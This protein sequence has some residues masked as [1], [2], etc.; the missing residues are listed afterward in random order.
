MSTYY[1]PTP[2]PKESELD[3][4]EFR[5]RLESWASYKMYSGVKMR[6]NGDWYAFYNDIVEGPFET[7]VAA[8]RRWDTLCYGSEKDV[9]KLNFPEKYW[10]R[11][12][13]LPNLNYY[14]P[15][16]KKNVQWV[17]PTAKKVAEYDIPVRKGKPLSLRETMKILRG[18]GALNIRVLNLHNHSTLGNW[19]LF[20]TGSSLSHEKRI[21]DTIV[22]YLRKRQLKNIPIRVTDRDESEWMVVD[23][24][25]VI[26]NIFS[27]RYRIARDLEDQWELMRPGKNRYESWTEEQLQERFGNIEEKMEALSL[28]SLIHQYQQRVEQENSPNSSF[29]VDEEEVNQLKEEIEKEE[30]EEKEKEEK[31]EEE[32]EY[33]MNDY[34]MTK[35]DFEKLRNDD[36]TITINGQR[37]QIEEVSDV[38]KE[39]IRDEQVPFIQVSESNPRRERRKK[40]RENNKRR[41][42]V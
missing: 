5:T 34:Y 42:R 18:E 11:G 39:D 29:L 41:Y 35:E 40:L 14:N 9:N 33:E 19:M 1:D 17:P 31:E 30:Q 32:P 28:D 6:K 16:Q 8:A 27:P 7:S 3:P 24:D 20:V 23:G 26:T 2:V 38:G 22:H 4:E 10:M 37:L 36:G 15:E 21:G 13:G 25:S 12:E